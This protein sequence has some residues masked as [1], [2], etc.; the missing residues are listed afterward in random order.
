[1]QSN[2]TLAGWDLTEISMMYVLIAVVIVLAL[3]AAIGAWV[4]G[5][6]IRR[7]DAESL[8]SANEERQRE[9]IARLEKLLAEARETN[10]Q[11]HA[12]AQQA[13]TTTRQDQ[14][15]V[16]EQIASHV[17]AQSKDMASR[18]QDLDQQVSRSR[19]NIEA[20]L[21][22]AT[23]NHNAALSDEMEL[24]ARKVN[25]SE[26]RVM[27][28]LGEVT[29]SMKQLQ[30]QMSQAGDQIRSALME[31]S[32]QQKEQ[33]A[34][35]TI[36]LCDA[37][38]NSLGTLKS[39]IATQLQAGGSEQDV[40]DAGSAYVV[41][42]KAIDHASGH[43]PA[44][45]TTDDPAQNE[46]ASETTAG[47]DAS[48]ASAEH[49]HH[50]ADANLDIERSVAEAGE[51]ADHLGAVNAHQE[52]GAASEAPENDSAAADDDQAEREDRPQY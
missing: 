46:N 49:D 31:I 35:S 18:M 29:D 13:H 41:P 51:S 32:Q 40:I 47:A 7:E 43:G 38:I 44:E 8:F 30:V 6:G 16:Q 52:Y 21:N 3:L 37:L 28:S 27:A 2:V 45:S 25:E 26:R 20:A 14:E 24:L 15:R 36:Q 19:I 42:D 11:A 33:K 39:S 1:M 23:Q 34:Q 50:N 17:S 12:W 5:G 22:K 48:H 4:R 10:E 9:E